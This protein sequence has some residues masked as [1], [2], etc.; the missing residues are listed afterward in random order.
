MGHW[1]KQRCLLTGPGQWHGVPWDLSAMLSPALGRGLQQAAPQGWPEH[2]GGLC[3][4]LHGHTNHANLPGRGCH[5]HSWSKAAQLGKGPAGYRGEAAARLRHAESLEAGS[6]PIGGRGFSAGHRLSPATPLAGGSAQSPCSQEG[7]EV[8]R[9]RAAGGL[10]P[11][12]PPPHRLGT[13]D[14]AV[15]HPSSPLPPS[16]RRHP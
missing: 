10:R 9:G 6:E 2:R 7:G 1:F 11:H 14:P 13:P 12:P 3:S 16:T 8:P 15:P 5:R 4:V